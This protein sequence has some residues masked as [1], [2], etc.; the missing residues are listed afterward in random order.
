M[1]HLS[2]IR[3]TAFLGICLSA[4]MLLM[5][6]VAL[7]NGEAETTVAFLAGSFFT[8]A[9]CSAVFAST[10][11]PERPAKVND[12]L[13][14]VILWCLLSPIPAAVPFYLGTEETDFL[15][16]MHEAASC[17]T[18]TGHS[19]LDIE[20]DSWPPSLLVWRGMLHLFGL[21]FSLVTTASVFAAIGFSGPGVHRSVLFTIPQGSFF[22][23]APRVARLVAA[24]SATL[25]LLLFS[26]LVIS[27]MTGVEA[28]EKAISITSTGLVDPRE[29]A[30]VAPS[31][32]QSFIMFVG[33][34][35]ATAGLYVMMDLTPARIR[36]IT[37]DPELTALMSLIVFVGILASVAGLGIFASIGWALSALS[38]SGVPIWVDRPTALATIPAALILVPT[39][40]GGAALSTA[41]GI[42]LARTIILIRRAG[43]EFARLGYQRSVVALRYRNRQQE[44]R[45]VLGVWVYL[46]AYVGAATAI[47]ISLSFQGGDLTAALINAV[48]AISNSGWIISILPTATTTEHFVL[49][50]AMIL[51]RL[52]IIALLPALSPA[53]WRK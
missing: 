50:G 25:I 47:F 29:S 12:A 44:E 10:D 51:G 53:F 17:L 32:I 34:F 43:Q 6:L 46:I 45:A 39:M 48:G 52:E 38:T 3:F 37:I 27:G 49:I 21:M 11:K 5:V 40:I 8:A 24:I 14:V 16:A 4:V 20:D 28:L 42:K 22:E 31:W 36:S 1:N 23:A 35:F 33:L 30:A 41:G 18:T 26:L 19:V 15:V 2:V 9:L 13:A 7:A